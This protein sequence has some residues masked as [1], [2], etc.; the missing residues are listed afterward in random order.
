M[1]DLE[2]QLVSDLGAS[3]TGTPSSSPFQ[4]VPGASSST[5]LVFT[6]PP[7]LPI[8]SV[9]TVSLSVILPACNCNGFDSIQLTPTFSPIPTPEPTSF[10]L[11]GL[12][13]SGLGL[14]RFRG[15][16]S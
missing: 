8:G 3:Y 5:F 14:V 15:R 16:R 7:P 6:A 12:G 11:M 4:F 13:L 1:E 2:I 10:A 9:E